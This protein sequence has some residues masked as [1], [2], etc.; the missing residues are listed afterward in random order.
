MHVLSRESH[1][2]SK[3]FPAL[4]KELKFGWAAERSSDHRDEWRPGGGSAGL[5]HGRFGRHHPP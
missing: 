3:N 5:F 4:P 1:S 2:F